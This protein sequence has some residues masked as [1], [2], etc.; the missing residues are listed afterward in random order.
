MAKQKPK[1]VNIMTPEFRASF[2]NVFRPGKPVQEGQEPKYSI[3]A[4]FAPGLD[5]GK[6]AYGTLIS[7]KQAV[8]D[9]VTEK[10]GPNKEDWPSGL[11]LPFRKQGEKKYDGY[12]ED[13]IY[14]TATSKQK[15]GLVD[16]SNIDIIDEHEFYSGCYARATV[17][18]FAYDK[19]G[20]RGVAF[21]LQNVQKLRD[22]DPLSGRMKAQDEF[23]PVVTDDDQGT[24]EAGPSIDDLLG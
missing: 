15:P 24:G 16:A 19:A 23:E 14:I 12:V 17:R 9:A 10:W 22:G 20:N 2:V 11:R 4:L 18:A 6:P 5:L 3:V 8:L 13:G 1:A 7:L 21:G